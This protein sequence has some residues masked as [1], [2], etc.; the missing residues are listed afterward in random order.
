M[1]V[2]Q[3]PARVRPLILA[4]W[5]AVYYTGRPATGTSYRVWGLFPTRQAAAGF[6]GNITGRDGV[7]D[8]AE[9]EI[10]GN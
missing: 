5:F 8:R 4:G 2:D 9:F 6:V 10:V 1:T 7:Y 3:L